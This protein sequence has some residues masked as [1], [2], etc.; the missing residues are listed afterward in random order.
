MTDIPEPL[1]D[2]RSSWQPGAEYT[3]DSNVDYVKDYLLK[4]LAHF[5][6]CKIHPGGGGARAYR[7]PVFLL[8]GDPYEKLPYEGDINY[9]LSCLAPAAGRIENRVK[10]YFKALARIHVDRIDQ[11]AAELG[12]SRDEAFEV[13]KQKRFDLSDCAEGET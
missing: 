5:K 7:R 4:M 6:E 8:P 3:A 9:G 11:L 12:C 1:N 2:N 13:W 10:A